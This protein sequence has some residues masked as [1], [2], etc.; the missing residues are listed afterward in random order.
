VGFGQGRWEDYIQGSRLQSCCGKNRTRYKCTDVC[1]STLKRK[2]PLAP[3]L[4]GCGW[5]SHQP[6]DLVLEKPSLSQR[7]AWGSNLIPSPDTTASPSRGTPAK[8]GSSVSHQSLGPFVA[9][10]EVSLR[11]RKVLYIVCTSLALASPHLSHVCYVLVLGYKP[12][13]RLRPKL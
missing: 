10:N 6:N 3:C 8:C 9:G 1:R 2:N 12:P 4:S 13:R 7:L 5:V 11:V